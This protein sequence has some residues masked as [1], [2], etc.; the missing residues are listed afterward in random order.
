MNSNN[1]NNMAQNATAQDCKTSE[2]KS[3]QP[4]IDKIKIAQQ[5][6]KYLY[7]LN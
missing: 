4:I 5:K 7:L 6:C 3:I 2:K 1:N